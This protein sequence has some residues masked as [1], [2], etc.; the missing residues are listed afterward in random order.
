VQRERCA[1]QGGNAAFDRGKVS[2]R[3]SSGIHPSGS[4]SGSATSTGLRARSRS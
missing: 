1:Q 3:R 2:G 4:S